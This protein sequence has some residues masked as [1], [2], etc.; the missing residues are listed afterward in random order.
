[1]PADEARKLTDRIKTDAESLW[2]LIKQ[3]NPSAGPAGIAL[4]DQKDADAYCIR[5]FGSAHLRLPREERPKMVASL[6]QSGLSIRAIASATGV[7]HQTV[8]NDL[9]AEK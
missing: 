5:E 8:A 7:N 3:A 2:E 1:M 4:D 9:Y 6:R